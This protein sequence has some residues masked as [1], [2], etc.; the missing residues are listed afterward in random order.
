MFKESP[1]LLWWS[2]SEAVHFIELQI[3]NTEF[4]SIPELWEYP[5]PPP[6]LFTDD[7]RFFPVP[8]TEQ[9]ATCSECSG[10]GKIKCPDCR[11]TGRI[12]TRVRDPKTKRYQY[13]FC[14]ELSE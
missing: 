2:G 9:K 3:D 7:S 13:Y 4:G 12:R 11:G 10:S 6:P 5:I 14:F 8:H 1:N